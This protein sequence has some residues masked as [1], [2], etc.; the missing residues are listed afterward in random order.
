MRPRLPFTPLAFLVVVTCLVGRAHMFA[1]ETMSGPATN[2]P[3]N[4]LFILADDMGWNQ[5]G[6]SGSSFYETPNI[7]RIAH[8]GVR[9]TNAYC[10]AP[11][12]TP[13]RAAILTGRA[14]ARIHLTEYIPGDPYPWAKLRAPA[15]VPMLAL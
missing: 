6:Y 4:F 9:F 3:L 11:I 8:D 14:P 15:E 13:S 12:C 7:D 1:A 10:A 5:T 2:R